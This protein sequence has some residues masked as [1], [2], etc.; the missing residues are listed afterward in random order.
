MKDLK[1]IKNQ[2]ISA[3][4]HPEAE[5]GLYFR[6]LFHL[7]EEDER[8]AVVAEQVEILEALKELISEDKIKMDESGEEAIFKLKNLI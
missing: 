8:P 2:I 5:E 4:S 6:N 1:K 3:L 7:H